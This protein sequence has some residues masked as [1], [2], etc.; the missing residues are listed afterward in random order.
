MANPQ[1]EEGYTAI[2]HKLLE[3]LARTRINGEARQILD[4]IF[5]KT[6]GFH[7]TEDE[8]ALS[9]F[10]EAT[11]LKKNSACRAIEKL[12]VMGIITVHEKVNKAKSYKINK[13]YDKW[14]PLPKKRTIIHEK[15]NKQ[16]T[17][18][19]TTK[20]TTK[21]KRYK[22]GKAAK[23]QPPK[24]QFKVHISA[25]DMQEIVDLF[26]PLNPA[27]KT[28]F[29][30]TTERKAINRIVDLLSVM[31]DKV[32]IDGRQGIQKLKGMLHALP[33]IV[34]KPYAPKITSPF[35]LYKD[36]GRLI[37]FF[38]QEKNKEAGKGKGITSADNITSDESID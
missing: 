33:E 13:D 2:A 20:D 26:E 38:K 21:G 31:P 11:G 8:I 14:L 9:Q 10:C 37:L 19:S 30:N 34:T 18:K 32:T 4:V 1:K 15:V 22:K 6:Y 16:V 25:L 12:V 7:K 27:Y 28:F 5:R 35:Q 17:K 23:P 29:K 24:E 36:L 3:A